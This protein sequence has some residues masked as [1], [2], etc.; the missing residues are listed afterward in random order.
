MQRNNRNPEELL[1]QAINDIRQESLDSSV[2]NEAA[3]RVW[4][5]LSNELTEE[6]IVMATQ[7]E[8]EQIR[9]C[10]DFQ[11][12]MPAY[13]SGEV[14]GARKLLLEDHTRE[15]VPCRRALKQLREANAPAA[16]TTS[17]AKSGWTAKYA[18]LSSGRKAA[19]RWGIAAMLVVGVGLAA[20]PF[21]ERFYYSLQALNTVVQAAD[22]SLYRVNENTTAPLTT[23][24]EVAKGEKIRTARDAGAVMKLPDGSLIEMRERSEFWISE[25]AQ[26]TTIHL[27][28]GNIIVQAAKQ[29]EGRHLFVATPD[30]T[31][32]VVGTI[33]SVNAGTKGSRV[34]VLEGEVRVNSNGREWKLLPGDQV[35][36][37]D[38][39]EKVALQEEIA[40]SRNAD[41]YKQLLAELAKMR[42]ELETQVSRPG[43]RY[44]TRLL[45][46]TPENTAIY[47]AIPNISQMLSEASKL[48]QER[49]AQNPALN[50]WLQKDGRAGEVNQVVE[51][52]REF[53]SYLGAEI[54]VAV[55]LNAQGHPGEPLVLA[56]LND[57]S[58]FR[59]YVEN[60][61]ANEAHGPKLRFV[62]DPAH[63]IVGD[64]HEL[65]VW[66]NA[67]LLVAA[68]DLATLQQTAA[69]IGSQQR[70]AATP[71]YNSI[72]SLYREGAGLIVAADLEH[73]IGN[74]INRASASPNA[75][76]EKTAA[77]QL[78]L[79]NF[80]HF[81]A[82]LKEKDGKPYNR[83]IVTFA[84]A[85]RGIASW[86]AAP[87]PM[88]A[89]DFISPDAS[90][91]A[92]FVVKKPSL[93]VDDI[94]AA[95]SAADMK[96]VDQLRQFEAEHGFSIRN[97]LA[98][99]LGGEF[100]FAIDGPM[101]PLPAWKM[102]FEV[103]DQNHLQQSLEKVADELNRWAAT[104]GKKGVIW[105]NAEVGGRQFYTLKSMD[106]GFELNY[107]FI[108][109]YFVGGPSR[110]LVERAL[111]Y[112]ETGYSLKQSPKFVA[113]LPADGNANF[114][115]LFWNNLSKVVAPV[116]KQIGNFSGNLPQEQKEMMKAMGE[117]TPAML[118]YAYSYGDRVVFSI[119]TENGPLGLTAGSLFSLPGQFMFGNIF[120]KGAMK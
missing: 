98:E 65:L 61:L 63:A 53:G 59:S 23:G 38:S 96:F 43:L 102:V 119:G 104:Q 88:G 76:K 33:F 72:A 81:I 70:G 79:T 9:G 5:R 99:P 30:S 7:Q 29:K 49:L 51:K 31:V 39:I 50:N 54:V 6:Q 90:V 83:A 77:R 16:V 120:G 22:G 85:N 71:F 15:C 114:S 8:V 35:T 73:I 26:G 89:L 108:N 107:T 2:V 55:S 91:A 25:D 10:A 87:G 36:T 75:A 12:L 74:E 47:V 11:A 109:G 3:E 68:P 1:N 46:L 21:V 78:G 113:A 45:A 86:L 94:F 62:D 84:E 118:A 111:K 100:A 28:R 32:S 82:E 110:A 24:T 64:K 44:D 27:E 20:M 116:A 40:W 67:N 52:I 4:A 60:L 57:P 34:S 80:R 69:R 106:Y 37:T 97:D 93:M 101:V 14:S 18:A 95:L 103:Y 117:T 13:L 56:E 115:A 105:D 17:V 41:E 58:G 66:I 92:A 48:V 19:L 42:N 112:R